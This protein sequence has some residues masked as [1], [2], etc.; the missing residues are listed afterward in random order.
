M[1]LMNLSTR[2]IDDDFFPD[3]EEQTINIEKDID[4]IDTLIKDIET[5]ENCLRRR[6]VGKYK[7]RDHIPKEVSFKYITGSD[8]DDIDDVIIQIEIPEEYYHNKEQRIKEYKNY[9][10]YIIIQNMVFYMYNLMICLITVLINR[11]RKMN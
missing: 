6:K 5:T 8:L 10:V 4:D 3:F 2:R 7:H 9:S 1:F 11:K